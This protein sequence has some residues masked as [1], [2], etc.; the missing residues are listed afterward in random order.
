MLLSGIKK[1]WVKL[2]NVRLEMS[3][4][5]VFWKILLHFIAS[6]YCN[7]LCLTCQS[8]FIFGFDCVHTDV[9]KIRHFLLTASGI[10]QSAML[11]A[12][13]RMSLWWSWGT[14][15][16]QL[17][18]NSASRR[19]RTKRMWLCLTQYI[20]IPTFLFAPYIT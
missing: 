2:W 19:P 13:W 10:P 14:P 8:S 15:N 1:V 11:Q 12:W 17:P 9:F 20:I 18:P 16:Q 5:F 6:G 3:S 7:A 4:V